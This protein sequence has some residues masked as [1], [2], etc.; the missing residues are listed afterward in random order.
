MKNLLLF[1]VFMVF[2]A[3]PGTLAAAGQPVDSDITEVVV[4]TGTPR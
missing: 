4:F 1:L 3:I 2:L